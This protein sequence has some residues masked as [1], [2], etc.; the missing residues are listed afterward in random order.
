MPI[1]NYKPDHSF[2]KLNVTAALER[3]IYNLDEPLYL[4]L[5]IK[6]ELLR[7]VSAVKIQCVP[8]DLGAMIRVK[9][10]TV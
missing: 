5:K 8:G 1:L 7:S 6:N 3:D 10:T 2:G 9:G 4:D